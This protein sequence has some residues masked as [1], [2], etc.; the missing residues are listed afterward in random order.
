MRDNT[1]ELPCTA[2]FAL[3]LFFFLFVATPLSVSAQYSFTQW[4]ADSG[5]PQNSV[6][7]LEQT[8]DG[9]LW[10]ATLNG[11]ARFDGVRFQVFDKGNT[12][13][14][15]SSRFSAMISGGGSDLWLASEDNNVVHLHDSHF[16]TLGE[17][18]GVRPHSVSGI[19]GD[20]DGGV[21]VASDQRILRWNP[22]KRRFVREPFST[23][24]LHF[25][26]LW[27]IGTG[28]WAQ[29]GQEIIC[30]NRGQ[31][32]TFAAP[33]H[34][35]SVL[36]RSVVANANGDSWIATT[37][38]RIGHLSAKPAKLTRAPPS[39]FLHG[40]FDTNWK[41]EISTRRLERKLHVPVEGI[42]HLIAMNVLQRD[43]E[44][45]VWVGSEDE[46]LFRIQRQHITVLSAAQGLVSNNTY[47]ILRSRSGDMWAGSWPGGLSQIR[48]GKVI[49]TFGRDDGLPDLVTSLA[50]DHEGA[51][52]I[53]THGGIRKLVRGRIT[54]PTLPMSITAT[55][56][57][58]EQTSY[59]TML[60]G[61]PHG[62]DIVNGSG[63]R[64]L[65]VAGG[66]A[67]DDVRVILTDHTGDL[68]IGGYGGLTQI[69]H[70]RFTR[71]TEKEGLPSNN[72]RSLLEDSS[73]A[74]WVGT[75][76]GGIGWFRNGR[77][78][79]FNKQAGLFDNGAF[80]MLEDDEHRFWIS[81]NRGLYRVSRDE[82][83]AVA[84]GR[85]PL[86]ASVAYGRADGMLSVECNGGLWPAGAKDNRGFLWFPTQTGIA[87]V[88]PKNLPTVAQPPRVAIE[89]VKIDG[90]QQ[91]AS[92]TLALRPGHSNLE[93]NYTALSSTKPDQITFR[94]K[95]DG[96]DKDWQQVGLRRT[97][98]YTHLPP[99]DYAFRATARNSDGVSSV[100]EAQLE[101]IV[102]PPFYVRWWFLLMTAA[103][104]ALMMTSLW[105]Y[106][107]QQL[108]QAQQRQQ[109]FSRELIASQ[110]RERRRIAAELHDSLGQR[111]IIINN[112]ALFLLRT[113]G[114]V[115]TEEDKRQTMEEISEEA[116]AAIDETRAISYA[117][118]PFQLDRLGLTRALQALCT[119][120]ARASEIN[121]QTDL[122]NIDDVFAEDLRINVYRIVQ[123][124]LNNIVKHSGAA[125]ANVTVD[126]TGDKVILTIKDD[127]RGIPTKAQV[128]AP[129][130]GG[131]GMSGMRERIT[132]LNGS[133]H[134]ESSAATGTLLQVQLPISVSQSI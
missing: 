113:K 6:R 12:P 80:R 122:V 63:A 132:L 107:V 68:W 101:V 37:D 13:G 52:W 115:R 96:V 22:Q 121:V 124:G 134:V 10:I 53:G 126:R 41:V 78:I 86:V 100:Q 42:D 56:Q 77:W 81:S 40:P 108:Q 85:D 17:Q 38:G 92:G 18:E 117:L 94:Y 24:D 82:L 76:D 129:G 58:I 14:I 7:G 8:S 66:L 127:G 89:E 88:D 49:R 72:V 32:K 97:A 39:F 23:E 109:S 9:F 79:T 60:F 95:L 15:S 28:F 62:L 25:Q 112:L 111:L 110:E 120:V 73:G 69:H 34:I 59:G 1:S 45:N 54:K 102:I 84:D 33:A 70:G 114:K 87:I 20:S 51:L 5:L 83:A 118:R 103:V 128:P 130:K 36:I 91:P 19:T 57:V 98:Y 30:F 4:T 125:T 3:L 55:A 133:F 104:A 11:V 116:A 67:T 106:R 2:G 50:E 47:P 61:T 46:G 93:I 71:W 64:H 105:R 35:S 29:R 123:E 99:G 48:D 74:I 31:L 21:W 44:G 131:F 16:V 65:T 90:Q 27:W 119:T 75:Y 26:P 43:N